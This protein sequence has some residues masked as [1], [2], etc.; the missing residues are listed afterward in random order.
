MNCQPEKVPN[1]FSLETATFFP[2]I[3]LFFFLFS[4]AWTIFL[5]TILLLKA[6][7]TTLH[8]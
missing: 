3:C 5:P 6:L 7:I 2:Q 4:V 8:S 1:K